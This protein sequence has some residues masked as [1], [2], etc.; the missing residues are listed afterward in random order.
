MY[1]L[2]KEGS[3]QTCILCWRSSSITSACV[4]QS[5]HMQSMHIRSFAVR[6]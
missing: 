4:L 6:C 3:L 1:K 2:I 5:M